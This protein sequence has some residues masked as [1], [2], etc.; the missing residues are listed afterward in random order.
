MV[1]FLRR[2]PILGPEPARSRDD[3]KLY[4]WRSTMKHLKVHTVPVGTAHIVVAALLAGWSVQRAAVGDWGQMGTNP[5]H[6]R[7]PVLFLGCKTNP[8]CRA[9]YEL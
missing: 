3:R 4:S 6:R 2:S 5:K 1:V 8:F 7:F 9:T